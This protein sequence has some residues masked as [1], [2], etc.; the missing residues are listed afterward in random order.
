MT[1]Y[2]RDWTAGGTWFFTVNL[3]DRGS[4]RLV[5]DIPTLRA[6]FRKVR[7][8]R[9][10]AIDAIVVL[11][12]HLHAIWTLPSADADYATRWRLIKGLFSRKQPEGEQRSASR[13]AKHERGIWQRRF[14]EHRI[15]DETD[16]AAHVD[17]VHINPVKHGW[18]KCVRDWPWSSFQRYVRAGVL[19]IDWAIRPRRWAHNKPS[20]SAIDK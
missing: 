13:V 10:F 11:P 5:D 6:A 8:E 19:P 18:A 20:A 14:W 12:D 2:R 3:A 7:A 9:P 17:Y 4:T 15:R 1:Q 16:F